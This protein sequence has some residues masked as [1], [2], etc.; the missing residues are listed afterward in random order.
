MILRRLVESLKQQHW[1][2]VFIEL[3]IVVLGVFIGIQVSNWNED[4]ET[5]RKSGAFTAHL[6]A[7]LREED[8]G[9]Q[10]LI[11]YNREVLANA[12]QA[13]NA[14]DGTAPLADE[15]LL[16]SAYRATQYKNRLRRR[17]TYDELISTGNIGLIRDQTLR[18]TAMRLYNVATLD[19][20]VQE[21]L[22]SRYREAFRMSLPN[23]VQRALGKHCG[24]RRVEPGDFDGI[25]NNLDYPCSTSLPAQVIA[26]SAKTLRS[27]PDLVRFLRLRIADLETRMVDLTGNNRAI[28]ESLRAIAKETP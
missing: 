13:V 14:L 2:G 11:N 26:E 3:V 6:K 21:G 28:M 8:W 20:L 22:R 18:D 25:R 5:D 12:N 7:D 27:N 16:V 17:G 19:N 1:T 9:Y 24:D 15:A 23:E 10:F 4:R